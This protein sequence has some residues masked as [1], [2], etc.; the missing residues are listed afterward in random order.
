[1]AKSVTI[2]VKNV[3]IFNGTPDAA[4]TCPVA[5]A[6]TRA[7]GKEVGLAASTML[8]GGRHYITVPPEVTDWIRAFDVGR[9]VK[10]ITFTVDVPDTL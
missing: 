10:P 3:D 1:M 8:V 5:I 7:L 9:P 4:F 2:E 6:A